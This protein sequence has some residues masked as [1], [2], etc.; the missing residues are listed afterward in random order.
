MYGHEELDSIQTIGPDETISILPGG[1]IRAAGKTLDEL[2]YEISQ[3]ISSVVQN[4]ILNVA[5]KEYKSQPLFIFDP[6]VN[7]MIAEFNSRRISILG[8]VR[9]PGIV[10]LRAP[11]IPTRRNSRGTG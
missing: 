6:V 9:S 7:V 2:R 4:P 1:S 10:E 5:V 3:R 8:A 11:T